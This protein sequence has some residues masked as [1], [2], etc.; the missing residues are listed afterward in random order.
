[1]QFASYPPLD[2]GGDPDV[3]YRKSKS[4]PPGRQ[5]PWQRLCGQRNCDSAAS[6]ARLERTHTES[7]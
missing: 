4:I 7:G 3:N 1:M 5:K 2:F 6:S